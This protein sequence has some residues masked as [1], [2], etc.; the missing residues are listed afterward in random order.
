MVDGDQRHSNRRLDAVRVDHRFA[1]RP[2]EDGEAAVLRRDE[3]DRV[4]LIVDELRG[5]QVPGA[6]E[7]RRMDERGHAAFD[8]LGHRHLLDLRRP[9]PPGDFRAEREQFVVGR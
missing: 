6:S 3:R 5:R 8:R 2:R 4:A 7:L 9:L 1:R